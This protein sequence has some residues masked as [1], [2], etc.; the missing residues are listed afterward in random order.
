MSTKQAEGTKLPP[1]LSKKVRALAGKLGCTEEEIVAK[2]VHLVLNELDQPNGR[3]LRTFVQK[4][5]KALKA[6]EPKK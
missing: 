1:G 3:D 2:M 6:K 4:A 5:G